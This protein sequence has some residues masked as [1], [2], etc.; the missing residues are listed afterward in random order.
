MIAHSLAPSTRNNYRRSWQHFVHVC[1]TLGF[2]PLPASVNTILA[3]IGFCAN[4]SIAYRT[5]ASR[6]S[7][8]SFIH[9]LNGHRDLSKSFQVR[10]CLLGY[11]KRFFTADVRKPITLQL[12]CSMCDVL[13]C[14]FSDHYKIVLYKATFLLAFY[15]FL[16]VSE[17][18]FVSSG[19]Q[20]ALTLRQVTCTPVNNV[21]A[22]F[23]RF[24]S[25]KHS[26]GRPFTL[27]IN[28][29]ENA[30]YCPVR[31]MMQYLKLR[32]KGQDILFVTEDNTPVSATDFN[33]VVKECTLR[34]TGS[35]QGYSTHCFRIG[36]VSHCFYDKGMSKDVISR[37]A[38][39]SSSSAIDSYIRVQSF[40]N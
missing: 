24:D 15:A 37:M 5:V 27:Q 6:L 13:K 8:V 1:R 7:T 18:T 20:H 36:A 34:V 22:L 30:S 32:P 29:T 23:I 10:K 40:V 9:K 12:L 28:Q 4:I 38:R 11:S 3:Y 19:S 2:K 14:I 31:V 16:R 33:S 17:F 26:K 35:C 21:P 25:F 39:W